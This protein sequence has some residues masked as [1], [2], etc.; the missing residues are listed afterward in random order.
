MFFT[1]KIFL[2]GPLEILDRDYKI[3]HTSE[4]RAKFRIDRPTELGDYARKKRKENKCQQNI[5]PPENCRF[6]AD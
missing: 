6:R 2:G 3:E 1:P 5:S 4:H